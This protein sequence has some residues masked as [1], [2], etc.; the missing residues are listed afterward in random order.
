[1]TT[2]ATGWLMTFT[3]NRLSHFLKYS[4]LS[5]TG[6]LLAAIRWGLAYIG[7]CKMLPVKLVIDDTMEVSAHKME[8][9]RE[10]ARARARARF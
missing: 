4:P 1:M 7:G 2:I 8:V 6:V 9:N 3:V 5:A 10:R